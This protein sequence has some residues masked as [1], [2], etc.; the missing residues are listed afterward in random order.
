MVRDVQ[1]LELEAFG[2]PLNQFK[3]EIKGRVLLD[4]D[5]FKFARQAGPMPDESRRKHCRGFLTKGLEK[6]PPS[7]DEFTAYGQACLEWV[8][9]M[10][11]ILR[12]HRVV[13][14]ASAIPRSVK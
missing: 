10:F 11:Q 1:R 4:K 13:L 6:K 7:R 14:F 9:G 8:Y 12:D 5:R 3:K 2:T